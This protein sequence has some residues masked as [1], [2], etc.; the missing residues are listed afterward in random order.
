MGER[1][2]QHA[3]RPGA[4]RTDAGRH[5]PSISRAE[6]RQRCAS[7]L[8]SALR[9]KI[10]A[11]PQTSSE[12][13]WSRVVPATP[14]RGAVASYKPALHA[15]AIH[16][17]RPIPCKNSNV[18]ARADNQPALRAIVARFQCVFRVP[19]ATRGATHPARFPQLQ[20]CRQETPNTLRMP[21]PAACSSTKRCR[22]LGSKCRPRRPRPAGRARLR[23]AAPDAR[24]KSASRR[25]YTDV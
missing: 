4:R 24:T 21:C 14:L 22:R 6:P 7:Q 11:R 19:P 18:P 10:P 2:F 20:V 15:S 13:G 5:A 16:R 9:Q 17:A 12:P 1:R 23:A 8:L 3:R 25:C